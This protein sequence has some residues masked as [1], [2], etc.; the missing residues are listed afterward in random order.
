[1]AQ[2]VEYDWDQKVVRGNSYPWDEWLNGDTWELKR[3]RDFHVDFKNFRH[4]AYSHAKYH[5]FKIRTRVITKDEVLLLQRIEEPTDER[6][7]TP[8]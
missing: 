6:T 7:S 3:G 2:V 1:M 5:G 8:A 4:A